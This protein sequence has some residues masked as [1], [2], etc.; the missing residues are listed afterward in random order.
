M[1]TSRRCLRTACVIDTDASAYS[2]RCTLLP[3]YLQHESCSY[4]HVCFMSCAHCDSDRN[5]YGTKRECYA[6]VRAISAAR[7]VIEGLRI[8]AQTDIMPFISFNTI[9]TDTLVLSAKRSRANTTGATDAVHKRRTPTTDG[10]KQHLKPK[11]IRRRTKADRSP[12]AL[13]TRCRPRLIAE[14]TSPTN[15]TRKLSFLVLECSWR[16]R[17]ANCSPI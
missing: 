4:R 11:G 13:L 12:R 3:E 16:A 8:A 10:G 17:C 15:L 6:V 14:R 1:V 2:L 9:Y 7:P 5:Y